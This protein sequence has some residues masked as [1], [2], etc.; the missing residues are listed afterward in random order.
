MNIG[1]ARLLADREILVDVGEGD[2]AG[3]RG[4]FDGIYG[5][6]MKATSE[7]RGEIPRPGR[8]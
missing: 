8:E 3:V 5:H 7:A 1:R 4:R 2:R 6:V